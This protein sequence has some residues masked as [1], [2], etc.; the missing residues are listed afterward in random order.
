MP[1]PKKL[2]TQIEK[3]GKRIQDL[4]SQGP[5]DNPLMLP[6]IPDSK[7]VEKL[8]KSGGQVSG[9]EQGHLQGYEAEVM[10]YRCFERLDRPDVTVLHQLEFTHR[11]YCAFNDAHANTATD[12]AGSICGNKPHNRDGECD[13]VV[14]GGSFVAVFEVKALSLSY[15]GSNE[16]KQKT[17]NNYLDQGISQ[18][19]K[20]L[21]LIKSMGC[22]ERAVLGFVV[23]VHVSLDELEGIGLKKTELNHAS[24]IVLSDDLNEF[25]RWFGDNLPGL[26]TDPTDTDGITLEARTCL[27]GL[28]AMYYHSKGNYRWNEN[29]CRLSD[30]IQDVDKKLKQG[31]VTA[32]LLKEHNQSKVIRPLNND[33]RKRTVTEMGD[34]P[35]NQD[36]I[37]DDIMEIKSLSKAQG[38]IFRSD[39]RFL[40]VN[41]PAGAGKTMV[42]LGKILK[43]IKDPN[44]NKK[45]ILVCPNLYDCTAFKRHQ[46]FFTEKAVSYD[47]PTVERFDADYLEQVMIGCKSKVIMI[48]SKC[49]KGGSFM[50][51]LGMLANLR[52]G[53]YHIM[54]DDLQLD[55]FWRD[56]SDEPLVIQ[57][58]IKAMDSAKNCEQKNISFW[59]FC[60]IAQQVIYENLYKANSVS[61]LNDAHRYALKRYFHVIYLEMNLRNSYDISLFL[62]AMRKRI[63]E[64]VQTPMNANETGHFLRGSVPIFYLVKDIKSIIPI[65]EVTLD[66]LCGVQPIGLLHSNRVN[67]EKDFL[68]N[69]ECSCSNTTLQTDPTQSTLTLLQKLTEDRRQRNC[70]VD[71][72]RIEDC[73]SAE[74]PAVVAVLPPGV[75]F[76]ELYLAVS[77]ARVYC[78]VLL[79]GTREDSPIGTFLKKMDRESGVCKVL[80]V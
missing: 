58:F 39:E 64:M 56:V 75:L 65:L 79:L 63:R 3:A 72:E 34:E 6:P 45:I 13:F 51:L 67:I 31:I 30:C 10:L 59:I 43:I 23:F 36:L 76:T 21:G 22:S 57:N 71:L 11:Q 40:W 7:F 61:K 78:L 17:F 53:Q 35:E 54:V 14:L 2:R 4:C 68:S 28:W 19:D 69:P 8:P 62:T 38:D 47:T 70:P 29:K 66:K 1:D 55:T 25:S 9:R 37:F 52:H 32:K 20:M 80:T 15:V 26:D 24:S 46:H 48:K 44:S 18:R 41:G 74:W 60:D 50:E 16:E 27:L 77:R 33:Q 49:S 73:W 5:L 12:A 42:M